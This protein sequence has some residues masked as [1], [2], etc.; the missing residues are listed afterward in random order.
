MNDFILSCQPLKYDHTSFTLHTVIICYIDSTSF[1]SEDEDENE[2]I[3][4]DEW[5]VVNEKFC[6]W[7]LYQSQ[8]IDN[9]K[10]DNMV[11][12]FVH[13]FSMVTLIMGVHPSPSNYHTIFQSSIQTTIKKFQIS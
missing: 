11:V 13:K 5:G 6:K 8:K 9:D 3:N 12:D 1:A 2:V 4:D 10:G 7:P